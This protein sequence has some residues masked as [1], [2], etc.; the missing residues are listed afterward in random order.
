MKTEVQSSLGK[1]QNPISNINRAEKDGIMGSSVEHLPSKYEALSS[2]PSMTKHKKSTDRMIR[3]KM[4]RN[5][6]GML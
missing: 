6:S 3:D 4:E 1:E 2:N 5:N